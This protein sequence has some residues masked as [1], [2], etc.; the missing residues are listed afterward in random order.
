MPTEKIYT[1]GCGFINAPALKIIQHALNLS[2]MPIAVQGRIF[3][4]KGLWTLAPDPEHQLLAGE[5][6]QPQIWIRKSQQKIRLTVDHDSR[7]L[8]TIHKA[9]FIFDLV[10]VSRVTAGAHLSR[11][12]VVNLHHNGVPVHVFET[13]LKDGVQRE[14]EPLS[15]TEG[16]YAMQRLYNAIDN[17]VHVS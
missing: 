2:S 6:P 10:A 9:H 14:M 11:H 3:G 1:D 15:Q 5:T 17:A 13:L 16:Q 12:T 7:E 4:S 8:D